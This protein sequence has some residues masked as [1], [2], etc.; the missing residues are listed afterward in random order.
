MKWLSVF[1]VVILLQVQATDNNGR[2]GSGFGGLEEAAEIAISYSG[3]DELESYNLNE[4]KSAVVSLTGDQTPFLHEQ[5]NGREVWQIV[6][7]SVQLRMT[8]RSQSGNNVVRTESTFRVFTI[9]IDAVSGQLI[10]LYSVPD[11]DYPHKPPIPPVDVAEKQLQGLGPKSEFYHGFLEEPPVVSFLEALSS[12]VYDP[13]SAQ[14]IHALYI[15]HS[16]GGAPPRPV[17]IIDLRGLDPVPMTMGG[18][19]RN[20]SVAIEERNHRRT[21][22]D[23]VTGIHI[24]STALPQMPRTKDD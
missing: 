4:E 23:A 13:F 17:W 2:G 1:V 12:L 8:S 18:T 24:F 6:V 10:K 16:Q 21:G 5:I 7:D 20:A 15:M 19:M 11:G 9:N 14:E 3:F 22:V